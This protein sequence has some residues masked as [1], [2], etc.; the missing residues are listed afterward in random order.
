M[1]IFHLCSVEGERRAA[2]LVL[3]NRSKM[4]HTDL[5]IMEFTYGYTFKEMDDVPSLV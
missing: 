2:L 4:V 1:Y 3:R 5:G